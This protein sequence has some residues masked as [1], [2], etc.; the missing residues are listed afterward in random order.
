MF[1]VAQ[2]NLG[3][4]SMHHVVCVLDK[5]YVLVQINIRESLFKILLL[6]FR[7]KGR[8]LTTNHNGSSARIITFKRSLKVLLVTT[9]NA[10]QT[11][12]PLPI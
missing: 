8:I 6:I 2:N 7:H 5:I 4:L 11:K 3:F 12:A 1:Y 9:Q 10:F